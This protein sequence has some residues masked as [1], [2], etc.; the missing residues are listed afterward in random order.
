MKPAI[1]AV[2]L[3]EKRKYYIALMTAQRSTSN[4]YSTLNSVCILKRWPF[5]VVIHL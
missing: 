5:R 3:Q 2:H 1:E 4:S